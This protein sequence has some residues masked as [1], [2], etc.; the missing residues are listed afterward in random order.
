MAFNEKN[1]AYDLSV[2]EE[3]SPQKND[4]ILKLPKKSL[5]KNQAHKGKLTSTFYLCAT[6]FLSLMAILM[7]ISNQIQLTELASEIQAAEKQL[8][9]SQSVY[10]QL[11]VKN[12]ADFSLTKV[13]EYAKNE[14]G[15]RKTDPSQI[16]YI[17]LSSGDK[18]QI[19]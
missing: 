15:M 9:E 11:S 16:E 12:E 13:E 10:T 5:K 2:F 1:V 18:A 14:L 19:N 8:K 3:V 6:V 4:N 7:I 17:N